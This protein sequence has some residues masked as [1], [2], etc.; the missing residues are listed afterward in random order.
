M[1]HDLIDTKSEFFSDYFN[2]IF[3]FMIKLSFLQLVTYLIYLDERSNDFDMYLIYF[4][5]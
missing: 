3:K 5:S 1:S 4:F 2:T